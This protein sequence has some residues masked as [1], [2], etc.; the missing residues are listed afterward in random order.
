MAPGQ[1]SPFSFWQIPASVVLRALIMAMGVALS[2]RPEF[3]SAQHLKGG[4]RSR[5]N[6]AGA[7]SLSFRP[8]GYLDTH[9]PWL[10]G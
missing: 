5:M 8:W 1:E 3:G 10:R 6:S 7:P 9:S 4:G 2:V